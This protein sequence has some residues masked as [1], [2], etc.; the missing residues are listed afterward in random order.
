M[1]SFVLRTTLG[2]SSRVAYREAKVLKPSELNPKTSPLI[3]KLIHKYMD[4]DCFRQGE[5]QGERMPCLLDEQ[6]FRL[7][8]AG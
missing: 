2:P 3:A 5:S 6:F 4:P 8:V 1:G 7:S